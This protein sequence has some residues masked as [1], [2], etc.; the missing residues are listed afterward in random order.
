[1]PGDDWTVVGS[2]GRPRKPRRAAAAPASHSPAASTRS[3]RRSAEA[4]AD[5]ETGGDD[6]ADGQAAAGVSVAEPLPGW[7]AS[8]GHGAVNGRTGRVKRRQAWVERSPAERV[9]C[10]LAARMHHC[11]DASGCCY[12][13]ASRITIAGSRAVVLSA[14]DNTM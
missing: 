5:G 7:G 12:T 14:Q 10:L 9:R 11:C 3:A 4:P 1:M 2:K 6:E 8:N 13:V